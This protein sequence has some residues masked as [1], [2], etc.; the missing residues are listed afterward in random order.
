MRQTLLFYN[1]NSIF[2]KKIYLFAALA[3]MLAACSENDLTAEKQV[4]QQ[5]AE[6]GAVLFSAYMNRGTTRAGKPG[7]LTTN[8]TS[9]N[10][11]NASLQTEGFGVLAYYG[12]GEPYSENSKP[13]FMYN[14]QVTYSGA[15]WQYSPV[16]YWPNEFGSDA[17][18]EGTDRLTFFAYA[19]YAEVD[20]N[21]GIAK[22]R[23]GKGEE[24]TTGIIALTRNTTHGDPFVKY[25][26]DFNP[27]KRVDLCWGVANKDFTE[28]VSTSTTNTIAKGKPYIDVVKPTVSTKIDLDFKH[29]LAALNVTIDADINEASHGTESYVDG[30]TK[31]WVRSV[32]FE[33]FTDKGMLNLNG[34]ATTTNY[35]PEWYDLSGNNKIGS[36]SKTTIYDG[37]RDGSEPLG[38]ASNETPAALNYQIVQSFSYDN[39]SDKAYNTA[40]NT[41]TELSGVP[42]N[43]PINLFN[44]TTASEP[45]YV[46][47][48]NDNLKVTIVYDVET[49]DK[50][51]TNYL[52][53]GAVRG[54]CVENKI[55]KEIEISGAKF[56]L[57]AGKLYTIALHLGMTSVKFDASVTGWEEATP[58]YEPWLPVNAPTVK[59]AADDDETLG[60]PADGI[61]KGNLVVTGLTA[62]KT[63][64]VAAAGSGA[65]NISILSQSSIVNPDGTASVVFTVAPNNTISDIVDDG[66]VMQITVTADGKTGTLNIGQDAHALDLKAPTIDKTGGANDGKV[67][68]LTSGADI[69]ATTDWT[70]A[71]FTIK[72]NGVELDDVTTGGSFGTGDEYMISTDGSTPKIKGVVTL[73][74][75]AKAGDVF[76][77][78]VD[79]G[80][81]MAD[82]ETVTL[83]IGG[84]A[85]APAAYSIE[86]GYAGFK[87]TPVYYGLMPSSCSY[88]VKSGDGTSATVET[89]GVV[90]TV[91]AG[92]VTKITATAM[93]EDGNGYLCTANSQIATYDLTVTKANG[94]IS[95]TLPNVTGPTKGAAQNITF[96]DA[97]SAEQPLELN[98]AELKNS[99]GDILEPGS[100]ATE[101]A[102][103]VSY[104]IVSV[105]GVT[106]SG[107]FVWDSSA[108][109]LKAGS[110]GVSVGTYNILMRAIVTEDNDNVDYAVS[111][112]EAAFVLTIQ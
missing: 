84:I 9:V 27:E 47:P 73:N 88:E 34:S 86:Y 8:G 39:T 45:I 59:V 94:T 18:S 50:N 70:N 40:L 111:S 66:T 58:D 46:I 37:R 3:T 16:K 71:T 31:I 43:Q 83:K 82:P 12:D 48:T 74:K 6:E 32:T 36:G 90:T 2:M 87:A 53:D 55:T 29:A 22:V 14:Q 54:S 100:V 79:P 65:S 49:A 81:G 20:L 67:I 102:G 56:K 41:T 77:I 61:V 101:K 24:A 25:Y 96:L 64:T 69:T 17:I 35:T 68:T 104:E 28:T 30:H 92:S 11:V 106:G 78:K 75:V 95:Y 85:F 62:G 19:P 99:R 52:A 98:V 103:V 23:E 21:T 109:K 89:D 42:S 7:T 57:Q 33:G 80:T 38:E 5:N 13:D 63:V 108:N 110:S 10:S 76:T 44:S 112:K 1:F 72:R 51:L 107:P 93:Q 97:N 60:L 91:A 15:T 26:A 105:N 4:V